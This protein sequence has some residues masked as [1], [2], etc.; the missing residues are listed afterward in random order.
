MACPG[1]SCW[2]IWR[3]CWKVWPLGCR[4]RCRPRRS[5][6][7][8][9][10]AAPSA[11]ADWWLAQPWRR[12][13]TL[14]ATEPGD[15]QADAGVVTI[16]VPT[17]ATAELVHKLPW[18]YRAN[19]EEILL[20]ALVRAVAL[21]TDGDFILV[22]ME[23]H[24]RDG[25]GNGVDVGRTV[26][27]FT[28]M[29]PIL[30]QLPR[31]GDPDDW[32]SMVRRMRRNVPRDGFAFL[33]LLQGMAGP[34]AREALAALPEPE[35]LFNYL[36]RFEAPDSALDIHPATEPPPPARSARATMQWPLE[37]IAEVVDGRLRVDWRYAPRRLS[38]ATVEALAAR[39]AAML[40][41]AIV[42]AAA[43]G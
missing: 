32:I 36:G 15:T 5:P 7:V 35:I 34:G 18:A 40:Q 28:A 42:P 9:G 1:G 3:R 24:G 17:E 12:A 26:G 33:P 23:H 30:L 38:R 31:S 37:V 4:R 25:L 39:F 21:G 6:S 8:T 19:L 14:A 11:E 20:A 43:P 22:Q 13:V 29:F 27:W 2:R 16:E 41:H 10:D